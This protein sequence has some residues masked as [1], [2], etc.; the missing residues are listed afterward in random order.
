[1]TRGKG[2]MSSRLRDWLRDRDFYA[3]TFR[4]WQSRRPAKPKPAAASQSMLSASLDGLPEPVK[5][6][7]SSV[8]GGVIGR[9]RP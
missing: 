8:L 1:V 9:G 5:Q 3:R 7:A 6:I 2:A 4:E